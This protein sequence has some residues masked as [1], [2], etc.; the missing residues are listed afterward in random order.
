M[1][2]FCILFADIYRENRIE[3]LTRDRNISSI[4]FG[5]RYRLIDFML[6][7]LVNANITDIGIISR[8]KYNSLVDHLGSG[9]DW[10]LDRKNGGLKI[11]TPF[12]KNEYEVLNKNKFEA[13]SSIEGHIESIDKEY[14]V[15]AD[16]NMVMNIDIKGMIENHISTKA[17]I[18]VL[19]RIGTP[20]AFEAEV[21]VENGR[22]TDGTYHTKD[23]KKSKKNILMRV[24]ILKK[25][26]IQSLIAKGISY[27]WDDLT[28]DYILRHLDTFNI[29]GY[30]HKGRGKAI[31]TLEEYFAVSKELFEKEMR[32]ELFRSDT[33]ILT[34]IKD[35][36][37]AKYG[38]ECIVENSIIADGCIIEGEVYNSI[39]FR[40]VKVEKGVVIRDSIVMQN[41]TI[42]QNSALTN[43]ITDKN[44]I[45]SRDQQL[46]GSKNLP[47]VIEKG[48][49]L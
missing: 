18:S 44:V 24:F 36:V 31:F 21:T 16:S 15:L 30:K 9:K 6:S 19:Y 33:R 4:P 5:G 43:V 8:Q 48:K 3:Q 45:I 23:Y 28:K 27:G 37:P 11:L 35:S 22:I 42:M 32:D 41:T 10:D 13:L 34:K 38:N 40:N 1:N 12:A 25:T 49:V 14:C 29:Q 39:L 47:F 26:L 7:S 2:A 17:D 20:T 46:R